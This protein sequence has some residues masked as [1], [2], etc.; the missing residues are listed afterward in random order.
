[1]HGILIA[2]GEKALPELLRTLDG[3]E[4]AAVRSAVRLLGDI[5]SPAA[6]RP[7]TALL[8]SPDAAL[9][10]ETAKALVRIGDERA[11]DALVRALRSPVAGM[12]ALA[13][14]CLAASGSARAMRP[15]IETLERSLEDGRTELARET[16]R[17]LGRLGR[18]EATAPLATLLLRRGLLQRRWL[19][20]LRVA[21]ASVL[22]TLPGDEAVGALAQAASSRDAQVR[23][24][25]QMALERRAQALAQRQ[26]SPRALR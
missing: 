5:Q 9:R 14:Y 24:A 22:G 7:L 6:V 18:A 15:L 20:D 11:L 26:P 1:M 17:A 23:R 16:I 4:P 10:E 3:G 19:R 25:A 21:A 13:V 8:D 12:P 2:L